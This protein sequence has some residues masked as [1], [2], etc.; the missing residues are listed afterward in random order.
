MPAGRFRSS[1]AL[2]LS[3]VKVKAPGRVSVVLA[4][5]LASSIRT[6]LFRN[7]E[8]MRFPVRNGHEV[9][10]RDR[11]ALGTERD[12]LW[13]GI[14]WQGCLAGLYMLLRRLVA[15]STRRPASVVENPPAHPHGAP[16]Q[17]SRICVPFRLGGHLLQ[18]PASS[19]PGAQV[20]VFCRPWVTPRHFR[21]RRCE[22]RQCW[23]RPHPCR[24]K[25]GAAA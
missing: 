10:P 5:R 17:V 4:G 3:L 16:A 2:S 18:P 21:Q 13:S 1:I 11:L 15:Q 8:C 20:T 25:F 22:G 12:G 6:K 23:P 24:A 7:I 19:T 9:A 14:A